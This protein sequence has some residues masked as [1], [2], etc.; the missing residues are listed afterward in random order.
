M[1][2]YGIKTYFFL[3]MLIHLFIRLPPVPLRLAFDFAILK[4]SY[5]MFVSAGPR[6][7]SR[8]N[9]E[10]QNN[11]ER[12][13]PFCFVLLQVSWKDVSN[14]TQCICRTWQFSCF[15]FLLFLRYYAVWLLQP[16]GVSVSLRL[17]FFNNI[18]AT[19]KVAL[20]KVVC[21]KVT[22][23]KKWRENYSATVHTHTHM[24]AELQLYVTSSLLQSIQDW[25]V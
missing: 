3:K 2:I 13:W 16:Q 7:S 14:V 12:N 20:W 9:N 21:W 1:N 10:P 8:W 23:R 5:C 24:S 15:Q 25:R 22:R 4:F 6:S 19:V 17:F 18:V 11:T